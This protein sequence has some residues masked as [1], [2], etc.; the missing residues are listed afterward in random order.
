MCTPFFLEIDVL[1]IAFMCDFQV[2]PIGIRLESIQAMQDKVE[3]KNLK[4]GSVNIF[5]FTSESFLFMIS[6]YVYNNMLGVSLFTIS[7]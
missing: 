1:L 2:I 6:L 5:V 3:G 4:V 7:L